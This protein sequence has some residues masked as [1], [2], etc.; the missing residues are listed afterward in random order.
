[1]KRF[2]SRALDDS[3]LLRTVYYL[4]VKSPF[5]LRYNLVYP[6][7]CSV[8]I[9][10]GYYVVP[11]PEEHWANFSLSQKLAPLL[12]LLF[13]FYVAS[14]AAV[15]T[16]SG[17]IEIDSPFPEDAHG[18]IVTLPYRGVMGFVTAHRIT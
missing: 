12:S 3:T 1:M 5:A 14:L 8:V 6:F 7:I 11:V 4:R 17:S 2:F 10:F 15:S 16:F 9:I 13:P 18:R